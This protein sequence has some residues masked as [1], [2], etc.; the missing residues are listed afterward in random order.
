[1]DDT[2]NCR[3][4]RRAGAGFNKYIWKVCSPWFGYNS[5]NDAFL[6]LAQPGSKKMEHKGNSWHEN[7]FTC[8]RCQQ[9]I[10]TRNFVL[11]DT[12]NYCLPCYEKQFAQKC[13]YC[14]MVRWQSGFLSLDWTCFYFSFC[15]SGSVYSPQTCIK[16]EA[17]LSS[18]LFIYYGECLLIN[19]WL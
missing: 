18:V 5:P 8:N 2:S 12:N 15:A 3:I 16:A 14:K 17:D 4:L 9:P 7:C 19:K 11:K 13:L 10:G 6:P 1:M